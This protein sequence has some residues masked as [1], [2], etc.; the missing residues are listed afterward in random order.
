VDVDVVEEVV[1][2]G[3]NPKSRR[4]VIVC[5]CMWLPGCAHTNQFFG[6]HHGST[7]Q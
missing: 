6:D 7:I 3:L 2:H 5:E 4:V 1:V